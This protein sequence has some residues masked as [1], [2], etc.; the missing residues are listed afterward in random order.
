MPPHPT[1]LSAAGSRARRLGG[2][3]LGVCLVFSS[4]A[5]AAAECESNEP[6]SPC[7][8]ADALWMPLGRATFA[9][10]TS[11][12]SLGQGRFGV[13][14]GASVVDDPARLIAPSPHPEGRDVPV[15]DFASSVT[16]GAAFGLLPR[17][18]AGVALPLVVYQSG[19]GVEGVT[20]QSGSP[21]RAQAVRDPRLSVAYALVEPSSDEGFAAGARLELTL[22]IGD[23]RAFAGSASPTLAPGVAASLDFGRF[24]LGADASLRFRE[25]VRFGNVEKG[26]ELVAGLGLSAQIFAR[27]MLAPALE[28]SLRPGFAGAAPGD[29]ARSFEL[30]AEWLASVRLQPCGR[31]DRFTL[32]AGGGAAVPLS[33]ARHP[34]DEREWFA[35]VTAPAFRAVALVRYE[36]D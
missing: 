26:S 9:T 30:P 1:E 7:F 28:L 4:S 35:G 23:S 15:V 8:E 25:A 6:F 18:D 14:L 34:G 13:E 2:A 5:S 17:L 12:R 33:S 36:S 10:L 21:L 19:T 16:L 22:P 27:P 24:T 29:P 11:P 32:I 31:D 3:G 20:S